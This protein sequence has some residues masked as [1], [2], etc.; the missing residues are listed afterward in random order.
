MHIRPYLKK[1]HFLPV[2]ERI[3]FKIALLTFKAL[4]GT[5]PEYISQLLRLKDPNSIYSL[6]GNSN[7]YILKHDFKPNFRGTY[8]AFSVKAPLIWNV[9]PTEIRSETKLDRFKKLLKTHFFEQTFYD[10]E[11][12]SI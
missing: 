12:I 1:L 5:A 10:V 6:R 4:H 11:D 7:P 8:G 9:L 2:K 3:S